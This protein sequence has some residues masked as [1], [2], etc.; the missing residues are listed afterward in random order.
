MNNCKDKK[1]KDASQQSE[2]RLGF[3]ESLQEDLSISEFPSKVGGKPV[4]N[5]ACFF[6]D[7]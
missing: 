5:P 1:V 3:L 2:V 4:C 6:H 7:V